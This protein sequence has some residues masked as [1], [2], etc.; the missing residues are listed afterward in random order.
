MA[1]LPALGRDEIRRHVVRLPIVS[2]IYLGYFSI[3]ADQHRSQPVNNLPVLL[4][5][6]QPKEVCG[7]AHLLRRTGRK[8]PV[9]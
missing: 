3:L 4:V 6:S 5:I 9:G 7:L 2:R 8:L 1:S